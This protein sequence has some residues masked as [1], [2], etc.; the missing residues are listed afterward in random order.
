ML[1]CALSALQGS[2]L[3]PV[4]KYTPPKKMRPRRRAGLLHPPHAAALRAHC[5]AAMRE[6]SCSCRLAILDAA[7]CLSTSDKAAAVEASRSSTTPPAADSSAK[8]MDAGAA[9]VSDVVAG[10]VVEGVP[11]TTTRDAANEPRGDPRVDMMT[12]PFRGSRA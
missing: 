4:P 9:A 10:A 12:S 5:S 1:H 7:S 11:V 6:F 8:A 2:L 3:P